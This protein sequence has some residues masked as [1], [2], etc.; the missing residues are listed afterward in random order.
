[1]NNS[2]AEIQREEIRISTHDGHPSLKIGDVELMLRT[3]FEGAPP[4]STDK[5]YFDQWPFFVLDFDEEYFGG[6]LEIT[7]EYIQP[8]EREIGEASEKSPK[9]RLR[10]T[11]EVL[12]DENGLEDTFWTLDNVY[13]EYDDRMMERVRD[14]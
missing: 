7:P 12:I 1:M 4:E 8:Q 2:Q 13:D 9:Q 6:L 14:E 3:H 11:I 10:D 5:D